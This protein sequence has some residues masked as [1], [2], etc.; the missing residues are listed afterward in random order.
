MGNKY[1]FFPPMQGLGKDTAVVAAAIR[2]RLGSHVAS[3]ETGHCS[4]GL[5]STTDLDI[6]KPKGHP[7]NVFEIGLK[8]NT[9]MNGIFSIT[10]SEDYSEEILKWQAKVDYNEDFF[11]RRWRCVVLPFP[12]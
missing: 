6:E 9:K 1:M 8:P 2:T 11:W 3:K 7:S 12:R 10:D 5:H 4:M